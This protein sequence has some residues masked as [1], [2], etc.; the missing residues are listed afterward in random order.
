MRRPRSS[1][2]PKLDI[3]FKLLFGEERN[4]ALL[5]SLLNAVLNPKLPL[6]GVT[7]LHPEPGRESPDD[8]GIVLDLR[9]SLS[10]GEQVDIEMQSQARPAQRTRAL[11]YWARMYGT[12]LSRGDPYDEL[13][14]CVVVLIT[15]FKELDSERFHSL[16]RVQEVHEHQELTEHL[17]LHLVELPKLAEAV[18]KNEEPELVRWATFLSATT[19]H[20]LTELAMKDPVLQQAKDA[21]DRLSADPQARLLAEQR[22]MALI[23]YHL[24]MNE[25]RKQGRA[26]GEARGRAEGE[27]RGRAEGEARGRAEGEARGLAAAILAVLSVR[28]LA[29]NE[30]Q[31]ARISTCTD[32][33]LLNQWLVRAATVN[34]ASE[35]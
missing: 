7:V 32:L 22:E 25:V 2:D 6:Q 35:L 5:V 20:E 13:R 1:L 21:L 9:V 19:D 4:K 16:F 23:S 15:D 10:S 12:Q 31:R 8:K 27:A 26:E 18:G 17:E 33:T 29:V 28:Q 34:D 11:Y 3:V 24:D 14:R 30:E